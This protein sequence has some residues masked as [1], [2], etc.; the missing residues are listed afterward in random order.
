MPRPRSD[1]EPRLLDAAAHRFLNEGVD[2]ASLRAI[3]RDAGT[4]IGMLYYY[5]PT[6]ENLFL[7]VVEEVYGKFLA[8]L[9]VALDRRLPPTERLRGLFMRVAAMSPE[10]FRVLRIILREALVVSP[11]LAGL[12]ARFARG[13]IPLVLTALRD[14]R[15]LG[16]L[17]ASVPEPAAV[18]GAAALA[19]APQLALRVAREHL[20]ALASALPAPEAVA[21]ICLRMF[22][23]G[24]GSPS[25]NEDSEAG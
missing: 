23:R 7:A 17:D 20:P 1:I 18:L 22:M 21:R 25:S 19:G 2:G 24:L 16:E 3:A 10:E 9:E 12:L 6:K 5:F 13:H 15:E 8:D 14:A 4:N 11:R